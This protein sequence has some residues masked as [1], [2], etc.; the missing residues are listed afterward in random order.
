MQRMDSST[1][2]ATSCT[3]PTADESYHSAT[4]TLHPY[5]PIP[6]SSYTLHCTVWFPSPQK[7][8]FSF[9]ATRHPPQWKNHSP[10]AWPSTQN[11]IVV[12]F[13]PPSWIHFS[14]KKFIE[15]P[16]KPVGQKKPKLPLSLRN[17]VPHLIRPFLDWPQS[18]AW[19]ASSYNQ[20]FCHSKLSGGQ[21]DRLTNRWVRQ[22]VCTK[23]HC[24]HYRPLYWL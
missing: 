21:T 15:T 3:M 4:F 13:P 8:P 6:H 5:R 20:P 17:V 16:F 18:P 7:M 19:T 24:K 14:F 23:T 9:V 2:C 22:Q 12:N 10:F 1:S 11:D